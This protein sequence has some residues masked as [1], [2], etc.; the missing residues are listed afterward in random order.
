MVFQKNGAFQARYIFCACKYENSRLSAGEQV[1]D[2]SV[3]TPNIPPARHIINALIKEADNEH[4]YIYTLEDIPQLQNAVTD[5]YQRRYGVR[6]DP[7]PR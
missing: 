2:L 6:L 4:N 1:I 5:W 7:K 3:G